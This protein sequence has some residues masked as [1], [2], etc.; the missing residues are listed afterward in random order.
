MQHFSMSSAWNST[1]KQDWILKWQYFKKVFWL[2][3][4]FQSKQQNLS[5][6]KSS[7]AHSNPSQAFPLMPESWL[8]DPCSLHKLLN[9]NSI[10]CH[11]LPTMY[12]SPKTSPLTA[13]SRSLFPLLPDYLSI[14]SLEETPQ[15]KVKQL[16]ITAGKGTLK[17]DQLSWPPVVSERHLEKRQPSTYPRGCYLFY[18]LEVHHWHWN[19]LPIMQGRPWQVQQRVLPQMFLHYLLSQKMWLS[20]MAYTN[21]I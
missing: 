15:A 2:L 1:R 12:H 9:L 5:C 19:S 16:S 7:P 4:A 6:T 17:S 10:S 20:C 3:P 21:V 8:R 13:L 11:S 18:L 14:H